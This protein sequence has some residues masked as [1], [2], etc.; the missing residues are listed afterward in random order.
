MSGYVDPIFFSQRKKH[1]EEI[2]KHRRSVPNRNSHNT[3]QLHPPYSTES[4]QELQDLAVSEMK[5]VSTEASSLLC[6]SVQGGGG[7]DDLS[8][9]QSFG[10]LPRR[11]PLMPGDDSLRQQKEREKHNVIMRK[12]YDKHLVSDISRLISAHA[13]VTQCSCT[14]RSRSRLNP[15]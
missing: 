7:R 11:P 2:T 12:A 15:R 1:L 8:R 9:R 6:C 4:D 3:H 13:P 10:L 14:F 5:R